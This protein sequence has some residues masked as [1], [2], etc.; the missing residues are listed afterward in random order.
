[1]IAANYGCVFNAILKLIWVYSTVC[2]ANHVKRSGQCLGMLRTLCM[3]TVQILYMNRTVLYTSI[4][5]SMEKEYLQYTLPICWQV[6][7]LFPGC[8]SNMIGLQVYQLSAFLHKWM[9]KLDFT[10]MF[11]HDDVC[12]S[13]LFY[14]VAAEAWTKYCTQSG[15]ST[16]ASVYI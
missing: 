15:N 16:K 8:H 2:S 3:C 4:F 14:C 10:I 12:T 1:M 7:D 5:F 13:A 11:L 9:P 6:T